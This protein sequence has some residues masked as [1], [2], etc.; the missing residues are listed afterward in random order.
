MAIITEE[1]FFSNTGQLMKRTKTPMV[2]DIR[3][4][5][6]TLRSPI[7]GRAFRRVE[8]KRAMRFLLQDGTMRIIILGQPARAVVASTTP[9]VSTTGVAAD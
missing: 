4:Y 7:I 5:P 9:T 3:Q 8:G 1:R 6:R 2:T